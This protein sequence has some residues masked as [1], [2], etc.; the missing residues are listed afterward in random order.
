MFCARPKDGFSKWKSYFGLIQKVY[1]SAPNTNLFMALQKKFGQAKP[2]F[3]E[4]DLEKKKTI[5]SN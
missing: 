5:N 2:F 1:G 3:T 4:L